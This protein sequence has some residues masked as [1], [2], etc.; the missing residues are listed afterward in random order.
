MFTASS[1]CVWKYYFPCWILMHISTAKQLKLLK[2]L[3]KQNINNYGLKKYGYKLVA[4]VNPFTHSKS[5]SISIVC[6]ASLSGVCMS[7]LYTQG[8]FSKSN[9]SPHKDRQ[10]GWA[11]WMWMCVVVCLPDCTTPNHS[12][13][14]TYKFTEFQRSVTSSPHSVKTEHDVTHQLFSSLS[15]HT[16]QSNVKSWKC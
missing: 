13:H 11:V 4:V 10:I 9:I 2:L 16:Q 15:P 6:C 7:T 5:S 14:V 3:N 12:V 8:F 1:T